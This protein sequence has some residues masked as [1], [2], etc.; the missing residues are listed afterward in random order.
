MN[1]QLKKLEFLINRSNILYK[2]YK[3]EPIY[4]NALLI[5]NT[6]KKIIELLLSKGHLFNNTEDVN[7]V[8]NHFEVWYFQFIQLEKSVV[9]L[10]EKFVF[11][12]LDQ[13]TAYPNQSIVRLLKYRE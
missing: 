10:E 12:R 13:A 7:E 9:S 8:L 11:N 1:D 2:Q 4:I 5:K 6:N 3:E